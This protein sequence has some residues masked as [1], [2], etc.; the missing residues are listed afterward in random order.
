MINVS[1]KS[2]E[3]SIVKNGT[4]HISLRTN[5]KY[6][7]KGDIWKSTGHGTVKLEHVV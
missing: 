3:K 5:R 1:H 7:K 6:V 4:R 2:E